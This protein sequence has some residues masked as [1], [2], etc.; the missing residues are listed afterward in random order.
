MGVEPTSPAWKAGT[1]AARPRAHRLEAEREGVEPSR[2][3]SSTAFEAAA[4][5]SWLAL[6]FCHQAPVG[7]IEPPI[8]GLTGRRLTVWPHRI[9]SVRTAGFEVSDLVLP[10]HAPVPGFPTS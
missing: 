5:A 9:M 2:L 6:P 10:G 1:F 7:G 8:I 3:S 4:I